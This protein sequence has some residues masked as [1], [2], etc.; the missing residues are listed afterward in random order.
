[1]TT[2]DR[3]TFLLG[4]AAQAVRTQPQRVVLIMCDGFGPDYLA[5]NVM[6][7]L[8][9][10]KQTGLYKAVRGVMPSVTNANNA[11]ICC[12]TWPAVHGITGN[13]Y[14]DARSGREEYMESASLLLAPTLFERAA[15]HGVKSALL[16]SKKKTTALLL[17]G[18]DVV[19]AAEAA[20]PEWVAR[21]G[22]APDIYS[23]EINYW[24]F[25]AAID[26]LTHR[27]DLGCLYIHTTDYPMHMWPPEASESNEHLA[28]LDGL[29]GEA[30]SV[31]PDAAFLLTADHGMHHKARCWDLAKA[32]RNRGVPVRVAISAERDRY[33][34]HHQGFGGASWVYLEHSREADRVA[35]VL[36]KLMGVEQVL[37][38][39][40]AAREYN[41]RPDRI[42]DLAV[43]ADRDT[44][45]G[46]L[47]EETET[48]LP[49][50][51]S[52]GSSYERDVPLFVYN[53]AGAPAADFFEHNFDVARWLYSSPSL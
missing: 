40:E 6:P 43:F 24:L 14:W 49:T 10:W 3:R 42:G 31:A 9:R 23:R 45:F 20:P 12:G 38:R 8:A 22:P 1:M 37:S 5:A 34:Q 29:I 52:H 50:Y 44:V 46:D 32:C 16:S 53:A 2:L 39:A 21:L 4:A 48:L 28:R 35:S 18:A 36:S 15:H 47:D 25:R 19:L 13:S 17:G 26:L 51:R 41:L 33:L 27:Q 7:T 11:S 30:V